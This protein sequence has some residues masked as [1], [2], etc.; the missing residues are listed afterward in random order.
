[1]VQDI[2]PAAFP[3]LWHSVG[4]AAETKLHEYADMSSSYCSGVEE[5]ARAA[6]SAA[7]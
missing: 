3:A 6:V 7:R 4:A 2:E 1:M 5:A